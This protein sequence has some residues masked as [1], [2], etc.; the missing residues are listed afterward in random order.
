MSLY[1]IHSTQSEWNI[2]CPILTESPINKCLSNLLQSAVPENYG[3]GIS[4]LSPDPEHQ[5][6]QASIC[7]PILL[8]CWDLKLP[9]VYLTHI[10]QL[11]S[12]WCPLIGWI[13]I[14]ISL[15]PNLSH[16][17]WLE[18]IYKSN[19]CH[20]NTS[21]WWALSGLGAIWFYHNI[22][23]NLRWCISDSLT[24]LFMTYLTFLFSLIFLTARKKCGH[25]NMVGT[26]AEEVLSSTS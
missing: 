20:R 19:I 17:D 8:H 4:S 15:W 24:F 7:S 14:F 9:M 3:L 13:W 10:R 21:H 26:W 5:L 12:P 1:R 16:A 11:W 23:S 18:L 22:S 25:T 6:S 2:S